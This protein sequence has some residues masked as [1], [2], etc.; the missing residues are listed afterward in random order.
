MGSPIRFFF[1]NKADFSNP[2][3]RAEASEAGDFAFRVLNRSNL[4]SWRTTGSQDTNNTT[5]EVFFGEPRNIDTLILAKHNFKSFKIE[6]WDGDQ[7]LDMPTPIDISDFADST[8]FFQFAKTAMESIKITIRG[9]QTPDEDKFLHQFIATEELGRFNGYPVIS[10]V[11]HA[12]NK[13]LSTM[14]SG[15]ANMNKNLGAFSC[16]MSVQLWKDTDDLAL[17]T[18]LYKSTEGFL[19]W[20]CGGDEQQFVAPVEGYRKEDIYLV[21]CANDHS[22]NFYKGIYSAGLHNLKIKLVEVV[23]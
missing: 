14:A 15:K 16:E 9:T 22:P 23:E 19:V 6:Y 7:Y 20:P 11:R 2:M 8:S 3:A 1:K 13:Q 10:N 4:N 12:Q 18:K 21:Q 5:L 17:V